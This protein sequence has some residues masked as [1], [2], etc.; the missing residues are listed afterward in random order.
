MFLGL[1]LTQ[2]CG[3]NDALTEA[4]TT[5]GSI[6]FKVTSAINHLP[7]SDVDVAVIS[8]E[9]GLLPLGKTKDGVLLVQKNRLDQPDVIAVLFCHESFFCGALRVEEEGIL[10][11]DEFLIELA[12]FSLY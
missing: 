7:L 11:H 10:P 2:T 3:H 8:K 6:S 5:A 9:S 1:A 12:P 4:Q